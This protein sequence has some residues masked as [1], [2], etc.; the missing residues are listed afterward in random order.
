MLKICVDSICSLEMTFKH[1]LPTGISRSECWKENI[2]P[3]HKK[4]DKQDIKS[5]HPVSLFLISGKMFERHIFNK[6]LNFF[7]SNKFILKVSL[8]SN[9]VIPISINYNQLATKFLNL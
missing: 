4:N 7:S 1:A 6:L 3:I 8:V 5:Y 2:D 9:L